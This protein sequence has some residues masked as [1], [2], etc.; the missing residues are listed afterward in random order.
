MSARLA[1]HKGMVSRKGTTEGV[2][3]SA[4]SFD[5]EEMYRLEEICPS[6]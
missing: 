3:S 6:A 5:L 4:A 2:R 1:S